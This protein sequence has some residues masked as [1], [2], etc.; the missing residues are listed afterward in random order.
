VIH[1][2]SVLKWLSCRSSEWL[3]LLTVKDK[4]AEVPCRLTTWRSASYLEHL[5][6]R[7]QRDLRRAEPNSA[8]RPKAS[9]RSTRSNT[10]FQARPRFIG[11]TPGTP[12][13]TK[14]EAGSHLSATT[15]ITVGSRLLFLVAHSLPRLPPLYRRSI[16]RPFRR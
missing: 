4:P 11:D 13:T 7:P 9:F 2:S 5:Q 8:V 6:P 1:F 16:C 3:S 10:V 15:S 12:D 14:S